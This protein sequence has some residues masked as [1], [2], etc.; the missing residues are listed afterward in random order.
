LGTVQGAFNEKQTV[1]QIITDAVIGMI[2]LVGDVTAVRDLI[3]VG[4]GLANDHKKREE[5]MEWVLLVILIFALIP[6][7]GGVIKG[8]GRLTL[9]AARAAATDTKLLAKTADDIVQFLNR[10]GHKNAEAWFKSLNVL[11]YEAE[12][13]SKFRAFCDT[14]IVGILRCLVRFHGWLPQSLVAR[15]EQLQHSFE[16]LKALGEKMIPRALK[17]LNE[18]LQQVQKYVR[19]GGKPVPSRA[20]VMYAQTGR[21]TITYAEEARLIEGRTAKPIRHAGKYQ[22]NMASVHNPAAL[23]RVYKYKPGF[24]NLTKRVSEDGRYYP[25][26]AA[27]SGKITNEMLRNVS[28]YRSF[29]PET[30]T[31]GV[32]VDKSFPAGT[33]W[34]IGSPPKT[35]EQWRGPAAVLDEWN[36]N[37]HL[38]VIHIPDNVEVP[39]CV[40]TVSEQFSKAITGQYLEGG[41]RQA[42]VEFE[43]DVF[44]LASKLAKSG[45]GKATLPNG[46]TVEVKASGWSSVNGTIGYDETV[47]PF[48]SIIERLGATEKQGKV[49][50]QTAQAGVKNDRAK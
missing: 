21:K 39:S 2:P 27:A 20:E 19:S 17:E 6:V 1:S 11:A 33:F 7:I 31:H 9:T 36:G 49:F 4:S 12:L 10:V 38:C 15:M 47:V 23:G 44:E 30:F 25:A 18:H 46:I 29:G 26:V 34:G 8:V 40:S 37:G 3:A 13:L 42:V 43:K 32:R 14:I 41:A 50:Q 16:Q 5:T 48:A 45:G 24:P 28:I 22:Q 35:G